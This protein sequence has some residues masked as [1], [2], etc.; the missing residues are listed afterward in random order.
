MMAVST[1]YIARRSRAPRLVFSLKG[2][3]YEI[4]ERKGYLAFEYNFDLI[5][6]SN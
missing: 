2:Y 1:L 5:T 6:L 4:N 3:Y